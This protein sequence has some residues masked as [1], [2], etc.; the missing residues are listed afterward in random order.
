MKT[1]WNCIVGH[2]VLVPI[3]C[4]RRKCSTCLSERGWKSAGEFERIIGETWPGCLCWVFLDFLFLVVWC[5]P[6]VS[7]FCTLLSTTKLSLQGILLGSTGVSSTHS[8]L[9][10][11]HKLSCCLR[12]LV[13][14]SIARQQRINML[15]SY[16]KLLFSMLMIVVMSVLSQQTKCM[17]ASWFGSPYIVSHTPDI[18]VCIRGQNVGTKIFF[19]EFL[20]DFSSV[21]VHPI[22]VSW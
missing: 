5:F 8:L 11:N 6:W 12:K 22:L 13:Q 4:C 7:C 17:R 18:R 2:R 16:A 20:L 14:H 3:D 10:L 15:I 9:N 1:N 19:L 21:L